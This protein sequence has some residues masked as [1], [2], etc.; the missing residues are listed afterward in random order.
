M[1]FIC[2]MVSL[3]MTSQA[4]TFHSEMEYQA[5]FNSA[6]NIFLIDPTLIKPLFLELTELT[7]VNYKKRKRFEKNLFSCG[8]GTELTSNCIIDRLFVERKARR[9]TRKITIPVQIHQIQKRR[10][11]S[12]KDLVTI[13]WNN[14]GSPMA[15]LSK[16]AFMRF[17]NI[18][19]DSPF[20]RLK[21][22]FKTIKF[23]I[24]FEDK[25]PVLIKRREANN[26]L[27]VYQKPPSDGKDTVRF[28]LDHHSFTRYLDTISFN[29][30]FKAETIK[31]NNQTFKIEKESILITK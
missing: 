31:I 19:E 22:G 4:V 1:L 2:G 10:Y 20:F 6:K 3:S 11:N 28:R 30:H 21:K 12:K 14:N 27:V 13:R 16:E 15:T 29:L 5:F 17:I 9:I 24:V 26:L 7:K 8:V 23:N 18:A 25:F